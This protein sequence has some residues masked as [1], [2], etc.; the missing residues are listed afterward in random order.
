MADLHRQY[1]GPWCAVGDYNNITTSHYRIGGKQI[2]E[3]EYKD[4]NDILSTT[5]PCEINRKGEFFT[6]SNKQ[7]DN[8]IYSSIDRLIANTTQ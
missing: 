2:V 4:Y 5:G 1:K 7:S 6:W 8:P 3:A